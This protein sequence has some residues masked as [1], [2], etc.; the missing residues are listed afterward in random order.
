MIYMIQISKQPKNGKKEA[1]EI[2]IMTLKREFLW[3]RKP[4]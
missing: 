1:E 3:I 2:S 4:R